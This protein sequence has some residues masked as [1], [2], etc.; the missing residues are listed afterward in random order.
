MFSEDRAFIENKYHMA[1]EPFD[2]YKRMAY[3]GYAFDE[4]TGLEDMEI[5]SGLAALSDTLAALPSPIAKATAVKY[6]LDR[7]KIDINE[8]DPFVG[9]WSVNRLANAVTVTKRYDEVFY[10]ML[11]TVGKAADD[12]NRSGAL[13][14]WADFDHVV[15]DWGAILT[16]GFP[17]LLARVKD[18]RALHEK[19]GTLTEESAA[20]FDGMIIEYQAIL[21]ALDRLYRY[22]LTKFFSGAERI[23]ACLKSIHDG[24]PK[25]LYEALQVMYIYFMISECFDSYQVRSLGNG[26]D[27]TLY[28]FYQ[29]D[30]ESRAATREDCKE[31]L[32]YFLFQWQAIGNYWGQPFYMGGT[33][34]DGSTRYNDLSL[35]ILEAYDEAEIYNP[36]IQLKIN[37]GTPEPLIRKALTLVRRGRNSL[38]FCC[39]PAMIRAVM[40]Y[41]ASYSEA[42]SMDIRGCY[43]TGIRAAEVST[44]T[45]YI[46][47]VKALLYVFTN[48][49]DEG[50]EEQ[51]GLPTGTLDAFP[52]FEDFY[53]AVLKQWDHLIQTTID[54]ANAYEPYLSYINPSSM[55]SATVESALQKGI[56]AY[57]C[58]VKYNNSAILN[59][60]F[61]SLTDSL[62]AVKEFVYDKK[63]VTLAELAAALKSNWRGYEKLQTKIRKSPHKYGNNDPETDLYTEALSSFF[64]LRA[65]NRRN[66]RGGVYKPF[67]HSAMQFVWQGE[68]TGATP[69]GRLS[70]EE[71]S[72]NA[73]PSVGMDKNGVTALMTSAWKTQPSLYTEGHCLDLMIHPSAITGEEGLAVLKSLLFTYL[74]N[75]GQSLQFNIFNAEMLKEA[76]AI[77]E[78]YKNLQVR[79][80]GWNVLWN[81][82]SR[83]EQAA[84]IKRAEAVTL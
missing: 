19:N 35:L 38:V 22:A 3:H 79:V 8:H 14:I 60:G 41:G 32:K 73:S 76:Q 30:I 23:A 74:R 65:G 45:G 5:A 84:Y 57:Q 1:N 52:R 16:L 29:R 82:L 78:K 67:L 53:A 44:G 13:N 58:G 62:M 4:S 7:T 47:A 11:P 9:F 42:L 43:E 24:A 80:C 69:D 77:P 72:K 17:G 70:G 6:V 75:G 46:N 37:E 36:K 54:L 59:C 28:P 81:N 66:A 34:E 61:A 51:I 2:P 26:L 55:Y 27:A 56:D 20:F 10:R 63:E 15:P 31:L 21:D 25:S 50:I 40:H 39:E 12:L 71:L 64:A 33:R 18:Y 83:A 49:Y 48:G 68:K